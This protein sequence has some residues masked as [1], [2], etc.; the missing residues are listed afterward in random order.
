MT[1]SERAMPL[2]VPWSKR[3]RILSGGRTGQNRGSIEAASGEFQH[4]LYL[5][6]RY[7]E[8]LDNLIDIGT[9]F[10]VLKNG[11]NRHPGSLEYPSSATAVGN[12]LYGGTL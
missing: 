4:S 2:G 10:K 12:A 7:M 5:L 8:L 1:G 3:M 11:G 9:G 6:S